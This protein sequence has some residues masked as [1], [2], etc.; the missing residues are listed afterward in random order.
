[1]LPK[2]AFLFA[3]NRITGEKTAL[4]HEDW[5]L[6]YGSVLP[7]DCISLQKD[8]VL[9]ADIESLLK[10]FLHFPDIHDALKMSCSTIGRSIVEMVVR[11]ILTFLK[12]FSEFFRVT[13]VFAVVNQKIPLDAS[14]VSPEWGK[15][16]S[17]QKETIRKM[18]RAYCFELGFKLPEFSGEASTRSTILY[19]LY[20]T[21]ALECQK[22][23]IFLT[24][25]CCVLPWL[26]LPKK[27]EAEGVDQ[28]TVIQYDPMKKLFMRPEDIMQIYG[29]PQASIAK[30]LV[31]KKTSHIGA[32]KALQFLQNNIS[33]EESGA[34][35]QCINH[36]MPPQ[37]DAVAKQ[38]RL[39]IQDSP[40][41][42]L[43]QMLSLQCKESIH[44]GGQDFI[45]IR[46][47]MQTLVKDVH[48]ML[49]GNMTPRPQ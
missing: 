16:M 3:G 49:M 37:N 7:P 13:S 19:T 36:Y 46:G 23:V 22:N 32:N 40:E 27:I 26:H 14:T 29:V 28:L 25:S 47:R 39:M 5:T 43:Q 18:I 45:P 1:M 10:T 17:G 12:D 24:S 21:C 38:C 30:F 6:P 48:E 42:L 11:S 15:A 20:K 41:T 34:D 31:F 35:E 4:V 33:L 8:S 44:I 2:Q 9:I